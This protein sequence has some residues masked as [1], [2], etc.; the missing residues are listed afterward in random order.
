MTVS[1]QVHIN[2]NDNIKTSEKDNIKTTEQDNT[3]IEQ[4]NT[5]TITNKRKEPIMDK[6]NQQYSEEQLVRQVI[7]R[8]Q[9]LDNYV[10]QVK[11]ALLYIMGKA[12]NFNNI[13]L[14]IPIMILFTTH[15]RTL[16]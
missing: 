1:K 13:N 4:D 6:R 2:D 12:T 10:N 5:K 11:K 16:V 3:Q 9:L 7:K 8:N 14:E 15:V